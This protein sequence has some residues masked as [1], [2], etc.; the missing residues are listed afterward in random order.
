QHQPPPNPPPPRPAQ[1]RYN[2]SD[3]QN[4]LLEVTAGAT[5]Y[6][7]A[8]RWRIPKTTLL[9]RSRGSTTRA[10][11]SAA[12]Q[13]VS[14]AQEDNLARWALSQAALGFPVSQLQVWDFAR[15]VLERAGDSEPLGKGWIQLFLKRYPEITKVNGKGRFCFWVLVVG[16]EAYWV[17]RDVVR[18]F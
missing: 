3:L 1:P 7:A 11:Q 4:A 8:R 5:V 9:Y 14:K 17:E 13:K 2:E 15:R 12:R 18:D 10:A 16:R 6:S